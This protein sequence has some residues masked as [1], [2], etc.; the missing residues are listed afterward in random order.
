MER[1][2]FE[3][4]DFSGGLSDEYVPT[5]DNRLDA[6]DNIC[7]D[8]D[9]TP[10]QR[11]GSGQLLN[12]DAAYGRNTEQT[13]AQFLH[14]NT[15]RLYSVNDNKSFSY[16]SA[17][18][19]FI[20]TNPA[21]GVIDESTLVNTPLSNPK[22]FNEVETALTPISGGSVNGFRDR[23]IVY[24][25]NQK[26][27]FAQKFLKDDTINKLVMGV[28]LPR[29]PDMF[30]T[31]NGNFYPNPYCYV[32]YYKTAN[33]VFTP[34]PGGIKPLPPTRLV[35][36]NPS[37]T[38]EFYNPQASD[39]WGWSDKPFTYRDNV[40]VKASWSFIYQFSL[41]L[42]MTYTIDGVKYIKRSAPVTPSYFLSDTE[43]KKVITTGSGS[44][45]GG[46]FTYVTT[47]L[48]QLGITYNKEYLVP[49]LRKMN[50]PFFTDPITAGVDSFFEMEVYV[51]QA[52]GSELLL[53]SQQTVYDPQFTQFQFGSRGPNRWNANVASAAALQVVPTPAVGRNPVAYSEYFPGFNGSSDPTL[54]TGAALTPL[55]PDIYTWNELKD[56][57][58]PL[59]LYTSG[60]ILPFDPPPP[61][62]YIFRAGTYAFYLN[63]KEEFIEENKVAERKYKTIPYRLKISNANDPDSVPEGNFVDLPDAIMGG[64]D[65]LDRAIVGTTK[66]IYRID[67]RFSSDGSGLVNG[68]I[69]SS[70]TGVLS[71]KS[72][73]SVKD[74]L[75]FCGDDG[76]YVTD[77]IGVL[78]ISRHLSRTYR[79][80]ITAIGSDTTGDFIS[81]NR[82]F[83][84]EQISA[85]YDRVYDRILFSFSDKILVL[86]L[87]ASRLEE[88]YGAFYGPWFVGVDPAAPIQ[89]FAAL[90]IYKDM[91]VR[92][93]SY[94]YALQM[95]PGY[96]NDPIVDPITIP[97]PIRKYPVIYRLRTSKFMFGSLVVKKWVSYVT[98]ILK[99]RKVLAGGETEI[100]VQVHGY[101]D[102]ERV[103]Q[104]LRPAHYNGERD[105]VYDENPKYSGVPV[106]KVLTDT[107]VNF[108][109]RFG[110][111]GLR[112]LSKAIEFTNGLNVAGN[113]DAV[114]QALVVGTVCSLPNYPT[115]QWPKE[116][117]DL[118]Q[119]GYL[120]AFAM[121]NYQTKYSISSATGA[122][123]IL[124]S[125]GPSGVQKW[126][127]YDYST[128]QFFGLHSLGLVY[129]LF[130]SKHATY[131]ST[132]QGGNSGDTG[133]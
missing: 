31:F 108:Q 101:N 118:D 86:E 20:K 128:K 98:F 124:S 66:E 60:G 88:G 103:R 51:T 50:M 96:V 107:L 84:Q 33:T 48:F 42:K 70:E 77:G 54:L 102:G 93:D 113:S 11:P 71:H 64:G 111:S 58:N 6:A 46:P 29:L 79:K 120:I 119:K 9:L 3:N 36:N 91:V 52:G 59:A 75:F 90:G 34:A 21:S 127:L 61:C 105:N 73:V 39:T 78:C 112:C 14:E 76:I 47:E 97:N 87:K 130:G 35:T 17:G 2:A 28:G 44:G 57:N 22:L 7:L 24:V 18:T 82:D 43:I 116:M 55:A 132:E 40:A 25:E 30:F 129:T 109:R 53:R 89:D 38:T 99:R 125:A 16:E 114:E 49:I 45:I 80:L 83:C 100:D 27:S 85:I 72:M 115:F 56:Q 94:G 26:L 123:L 12:S 63:I 117:L 4:N 74:R 110:S 95:S 122:T 65:I 126:K 133:E 131:D 67:G 81:I 92:G 68:Q 8:D 1:Q 13:K 37:V 10:I 106:P 69:L 104:V 32:G 5:K 15:D 121:D 19:A 41:C 62:R 23:E